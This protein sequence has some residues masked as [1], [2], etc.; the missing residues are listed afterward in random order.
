LERTAPACSNCPSFAPPHKQST[1]GW[2]AL[3]TQPHLPSK[4]H[5]KSDTKLE[6]N[7]NATQWIPERETRAT[8]NNVQH[9]KPEQRDTVFGAADYDIDDTGA[10]VEKGYSQRW[11]AIRA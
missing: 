11:K 7:P 10:G 2:I 8:P 1:V 4:A 5:A 3:L 6:L 9:D